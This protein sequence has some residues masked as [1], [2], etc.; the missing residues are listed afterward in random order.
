MRRIIAAVQKPSVADKAIAALSLPL[1]RTFAAHVFF[2]RGSF[3]DPPP[4]PASRRQSAVAP[5]Q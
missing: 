2:S 3:P 1:L 4:L 5:A